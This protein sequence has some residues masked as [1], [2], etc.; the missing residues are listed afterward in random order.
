MKTVIV[1]GRFLL[2]EITGVE[3]YAREILTELD[4]IVR[5][6]EIELAVPPEAEESPEYKNIRVVR[7]GKLHNRFWEHLSFPLYVSRRNGISLNLCNVAPLPSPGIVCIH[8]VK[9]KACPQ[10]FSRPFLLWYN[11]LFLN[12]TKRAEIILTV[13]DFSAKELAC[14]YNLN[15]DRIRVIPDA[16]QHFERIAFDEAALEKYDLKRGEFF[17]SVCSLEPNK[18]FRW[19]ADAAV[20]N[21]DAVFAVAGSVN[22]RVFSDALGFALPPN[23]RL[24]GYVSDGEAK[25]LM[26][27]CRAFLFPSFYEGFG[28][29]PLEAL[30]VGATVVSSNTSSLPEVLQDSVHYIDPLNSNVDLDVLLAEPVGDRDRVLSRY[31]WKQSAEKLYHLIRQI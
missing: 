26:R 15:G 22:P 23:M 1:N 24:L 30:S 8:D 18:N 11:L 28:L 9:I 12:E 29:P 14:Y 20:R 5:P 6:G 19:L 17:F 31:S 21:P 13:S 3:R 2:H 25:T 4:R 27:D 16:W 7:V 10:Y